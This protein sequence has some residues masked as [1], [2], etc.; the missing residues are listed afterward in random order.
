[1]TNFKIIYVNETKIF[2]IKNLQNKKFA[3]K[4][5]ALGIHYLIETLNKNYKI[6][7]IDEAILNINKYNWDVRKCLIIQELSSK[8]GDELIKLGAMPFLWICFEGPFIGH[9]LYEKIQIYARKFS[10][11]IIYNNIYP[12]LED[13][14][15]KIVDT[16]FPCIED[17]RLRDQFIPL[18]QEEWDSKK[19]IVGIWSNK[20]YSLNLILH[21][22]NPHC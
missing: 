3:R 12:G 8:K 22:Y 1:M 11:L 9:M 18:T 21:N 15:S 20:H 16:G 4:F 14:K 2:T 19:I 6:Y 7:S 17:H 5:H 13:Y 10:K